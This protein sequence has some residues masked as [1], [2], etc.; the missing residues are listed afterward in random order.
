MNKALGFRFDGPK[1]PEPVSRDS[2][3]PGTMYSYTP[4][5][6]VHDVHVALDAAHPAFDKN[7]TR[8]HPHMG[9]N[10]VSGEV[11]FSQPN[12]MVYVLAATLTVALTMKG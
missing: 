3:A 7:W 6:T 11:G 10:L 1:A 5:P 2:L 12:Q 9:V 4:T 8:A